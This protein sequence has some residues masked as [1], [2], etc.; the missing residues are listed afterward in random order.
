M[1]NIIEVRNII[2]NYQVGTVIVRALRNV[3]LNIKENEYVALMGPSGSGKSTLINILVRLLDYQ[4]GHIYI[5]DNEVTDIEKHH[6]RDQNK[7]TCR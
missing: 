5:D 6:L 7:K 2:K 4:K 1:G 3:S